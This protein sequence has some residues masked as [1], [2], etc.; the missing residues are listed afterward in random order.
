MIVAKTN[1]LD[2]TL[3]R[4]TVYSQSLAYCRSNI[5]WWHRV[6]LFV[7]NITYIQEILCFRLWYNGCKSNEIVQIM[8]PDFVRAMWQVSCIAVCTITTKLLSQ[9]RL[10]FRHHTLVWYWG[11]CPC[12]VCLH[13]VPMCLACSWLDEGCRALSP[14][15]FCHS[16]DGVKF[17]NLATCQVSF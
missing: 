13:M 11:Q 1:S 15:M 14:L 6:L 3:V 10:W 5:V 12:H 9:T 17:T 16:W 7:F 4:H 8:F 2:Y